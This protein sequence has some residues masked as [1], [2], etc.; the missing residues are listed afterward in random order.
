MT[1]EKNLNSIL[2]AVKDITEGKWKHDVEVDAKGM[3]GELA[4]YINQTLKN[5][6]HLDEN[7]EVGVKETPRALSEV[8]VIIDQTEK[9]TIRVLDNSESILSTSHALREELEQLRG[10][11]SETQRTKLIQ[12]M[13]NRVANLEQNAYELIN[14]MEFQDI[15]Q[16]KIKSI[17]H[18]LENIER[19]LVDILII[20]KIQGKP[21]QN[22]DE[23]ELLKSLHDQEGNSGATQDLVDQLLAEFGI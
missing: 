19:R 10:E 8:Q 7:L 11:S 5:L 23:V 22:S 3:I 21:D 12:G 17:T 16:Q 1:N 15:T 13:E 2:Q 9:A 20:F 14:S 4:Q 18:C 6:R